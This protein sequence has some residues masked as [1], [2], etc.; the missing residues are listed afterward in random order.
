MRSGQSGCRSPPYACDA[1]AAGGTS[2]VEGLLNALDT[3]PLTGTF[4]DEAGELHP[5]PLRSF[6]AIDLSPRSV[7]VL[8]FAVTYDT[9]AMLWPASALGLDSAAPR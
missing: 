8:R 1:R 3:I 7:P 4:P 2:V 6:E 9:P 5:T